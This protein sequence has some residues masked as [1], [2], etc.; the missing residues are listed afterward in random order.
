MQRSKLALI[1]IAAV[2]VSLVL[3]AIAI[4]ST[5]YTWE[6]TF[7][8]KKPEV[9]CTI[10]IGQPRIIG[11]PV[12]IWVILWLNCGVKD[13]DFDCWEESYRCWPEDSA[14]YSECG[15]LVE[16]VY[17]ADLYWYN[18]TAESW[19]HVMVLQEDTNV[20]LTCLKKV[21]IYTFVPMWE[22]QYKAVVNFTV[23]SEVNTFTSEE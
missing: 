12:K 1:V 7:E 2:T 10:E 14:N 23:D 11:C 9:K 8:V 16:G 6:K 20:T 13:I 15:C 18:S 21:M 19:Q 22:G 4:A 5:T 17:T 3:S